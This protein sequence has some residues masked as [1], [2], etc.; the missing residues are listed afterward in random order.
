MIL[1]L[2][3]RFCS[4]WN[5]FKASEEA[6][7][8]VPVAS[9]G[10]RKPLAARD[11]WISR[12]RSGDGD[13]CRLRQVTRLAGVFLPRAEAFLVVVPGLREDAALLRFLLVLAPFLLEAAP[14]FLAGEAFFLAAFFL[15]DAFFWGATAPSA[16]QASRI[17]AAMAVQLRI[18]LMD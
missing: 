8:Q 7:F 2:D 15:A 4:A 1:P 14:D 5:F 6:W 12:Y 17:I 11:A 13:I 10:F 16:L 3:S 9:S 18:F